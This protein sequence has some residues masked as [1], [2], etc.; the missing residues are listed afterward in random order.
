[1]EALGGLIGVTQDKQTLGL[2]PQAGWAVREGSKIE[3]LVDQMTKE[4][5]VRPKRL[6]IL[7]G[8]AQ[9]AMSRL[10]DEVR[11]FYQLTDGG[12]LFVKDGVPAY[13]MVP[14]ERARKAVKL[15]A[16]EWGDWSAP[17]GLYMFVCD[18]PDGHY[19][20]MQRPDR[21]ESDRPDRE[22][23]VV[24]CTPAAHGT[25]SAEAPPSATAIEPPAPATAPAPPSLELVATGFGDLLDR[26]LHSGGA[27]LEPLGRRNPVAYGRV[28]Y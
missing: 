23:L 12:D 7:R 4:H 28:P 17:P 3:T 9:Y 8:Q 22:F 10:P 1:M 16:L 19:L 21:E 27:A 24:R 26:I 11:T 13:R 5:L 6:Q 25:A 20:A 2:K 18:L 15:P 14:F